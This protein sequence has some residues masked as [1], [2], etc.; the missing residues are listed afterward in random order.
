MRHDEMHEE[1]RVNRRQV[2]EAKSAVVDFAKWRRERGLVRPEQTRPEEGIHLR[3][4]ETSG[5]QA[6]TRMLG[7]N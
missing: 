1:V 4:H 2:E 5:R 3:A 6:A 7:S